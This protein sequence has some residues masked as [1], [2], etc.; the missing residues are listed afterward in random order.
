MSV[1]QTLPGISFLKSVYSTKGPCLCLHKV[2]RRSQHRI[3]RVYITSQNL[4][5]DIFPN[6]PVPN[7]STVSYLV[8]CFCDTGGVQDRNHSGQPSVLSDYSLD[9]I[10]QTLLRSPRKSLRKLSLWSG[11]SYGSAHKAT[12]I[13]KLHPYHVHVMHKLKVHRTW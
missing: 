8:V 12:K 4:F 7:R 6:S 2:C 9:D 11:L 1:C 10:R 13:L 5:R 3:D